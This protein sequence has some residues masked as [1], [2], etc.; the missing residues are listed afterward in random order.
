MQKSVLNT[1]LRKKN[2]AGDIMLAG[3]KL[4]YKATLIK[5]VWYLNKN[6]HIEQWNRTESPEVKPHIH[7]QL[8][9]DK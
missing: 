4:Y 8:M 2:K 6:R 1:I 3:L 7:R 9:Y 5:T